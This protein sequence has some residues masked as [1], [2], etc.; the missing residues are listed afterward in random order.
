MLSLPTKSNIV[1]AENVLGEYAAYGTA[2][3]KAFR[4]VFN[5][6]REAL[7]YSEHWANAMLGKWV[8]KPLKRD[9]KWRA[10]PAS[11]QQKDFIRKLMRNQNV[12]SID[13]LSSGRASD[14]IT[15][16]KNKA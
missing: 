8:L 13:K 5:S 9:A 11:E 7:V 10:E 6:L 12:E 2:K 15:T 3:D 16:L 1:V 4:E 14:I